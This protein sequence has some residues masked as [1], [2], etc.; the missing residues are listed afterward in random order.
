MVGTPLKGVRSNSSVRFWRDSSPNSSARVFDAERRAHCPLSPG[1]GSEAYAGPL[2][3]AA[4]PG[5][6]PRLS[7]PRV[8]ARGGCAGDAL[9]AAQEGPWVRRRREARKGSEAV[10]AG[11]ELVTRAERGAGSES[12]G[13]EPAGRAVGGRRRGSGSRA[14]SSGKRE[15]LASALPPA[16]RRLLV[17]WALVSRPSPLQAESAVGRGPSGAAAEQGAF[18]PAF[19]ERIR[20]DSGSGFLSLAGCTRPR[21]ESRREPLSFPGRRH[22]GRP[23]I[24]ALPPG[25][26]GSGDQG[27]ESPRAP[28][29]SV[30]HPGLR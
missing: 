24:Q 13:G 17:S 10:I 7:S 4:L 6:R 16:R 8:K 29:R 26:Q 22:R 19:P 5:H 2:R 30:Q 14:A 27:R 18:C 12:P 3:F 9:D 28:R 20:G 21:D 15:R 11:A 23:S 1:A 25:G